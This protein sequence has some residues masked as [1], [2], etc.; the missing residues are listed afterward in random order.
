[1]KAGYEVRDV[2]RAGMDATAPYLNVPSHV[3]V[4]PDGE[5]PHLRPED[6]AFLDRL[7]TQRCEV[8]R[9]LAE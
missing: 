5:I 8:F 2:V 3:M 9:R 7:T 4:Q 6:R 1:M